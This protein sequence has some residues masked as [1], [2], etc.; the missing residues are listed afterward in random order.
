MKSAQV[1]DGKKR[2]TRCFNLVPVEEYGVDLHNKLGIRAACKPCES[3]AQAKRR[4][5]R[6][7]Q[8]I[9]RPLAADHPWTHCQSCGRPAS[10]CVF[11]VTA[12]TLPRCSSWC[13]DC[14]EVRFR[15]GM[16][17]EQ[18]ERELRH[19]RPAD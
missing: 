16:S 17:P 13:L 15:R 12:S 5:L 8:R 3:V 10:Q 7:P 14:H 9:H 4:R 19:W 2:C 1:I 6:K 18:R 11:P